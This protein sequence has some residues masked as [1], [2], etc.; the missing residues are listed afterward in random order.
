MS[1]VPNL[2]LVCPLCC[3][4]SKLRFSLPTSPIRTCLAAD[5]GLVFAER[6]PSEQELNAY[7]TQLYYPKH[8]DETPIKRQSDQAKLRQHLGAIAKRVELSDLR[9]LDAGC[10][11]GNLLEV[12]NSMDAREVVGLEVNDEARNLARTR[13]YEVVASLDELAGRVFDLIYMNDVIEHLRQPWVFCH[14]LHELLADE[15]HF[16]TVT[17]DV[18]GLKSRILGKHWDIMQDPTHFYFFSQQ[19]LTRTLEHAGYR[20]I[21]TLR[22]PVEFSHHGFARRLLQRVLVRSG[23]DSSLKIIASK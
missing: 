7:Y 5:C 18:D 15:G 20:K 11:T 12:A 8:S 23:L 13:G 9:V 2:Q 10:G 16:F 22:F 17:G 4:D 14:G 6:Q 1:G 19:S 21:E 3:A